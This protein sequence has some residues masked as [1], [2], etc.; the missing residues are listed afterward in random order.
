MRASRESDD[1]AA[2]AARAARVEKVR[3]Y[4]ETAVAGELDELRATKATRNKAVND[5]AFNIGQLITGAEREDV[6]LDRKSLEAR[7]FEAAQSCGYVEKDGAKAATDTIKSGLDAGMKRPRNLSE[8]ATKGGTRPRTMPPDSGAARQTD[9]DKAAAQAARDL[10][11]CGEI[12]A[13]STQLRRSLAETYLKHRGVLTDEL[14]D[15][16][17]R[18]LCFA[19]NVYIH[20][21]RHP[22]LI[23]RTSNPLTGKHNG[24]IQRTPIKPDGRGRA[25][26]ED[27]A[28]LAKKSLAKTSNDNG[29][30]VIG[31]IEPGSKVYVAEGVEDALS[32]VSVAGGAAIVTLG[33]SRLDKIKLPD[34]CR[35]FFLGQK[36]KLEDAAE[37]RKAAQAVADAGGEAFLVWPG[38]H[39]DFNELLRK[40]G[41]A[42]VA[43]ALAE[44]EAAKPD[45]SGLV[46]LESFTVNTVCDDLIEDV[47]KRGLVGQL[48]GQTGT[49]KSVLGPEIGKC[50]AA[51]RDFF[52]RRTEQGP[53][54][55]VNYE[56]SREF[57]NRIVGAAHNLTAE[58]HE[59][60]KRNF[61]WVEAAPFLGTGLEGD[62]G[63]AYIL[64]LSRKV[65]RAR[66]RLPV[67]IMID[68]YSKST[69]GNNHKEGADVT[70][71]VGRKLR[72]AAKTGAAVIDI[73]HPN[74][75]DG[76]GMAGGAGQHRND[77]EFA[78]SVTS[79]GHD[80]PIP[81]TATREVRVTKNQ[82]GPAGN[83]L[84]G[85]FTVALR[86]IAENDRGN[87]IV[88]PI[89]DPIASTLGQP[90][91][92]S[93][94]LKQSTRAFDVWNEF[95][96]CEG[97]RIGRGHPRIPDGT[98]IVRYDALEA[99]CIEKGIGH[100]KQ[101][102]PK[103]RE[104][105]QRKAVKAGF[106]GC[107][108]AGALAY[109]TLDD[110]LVC[111]RT[112]NVQEKGCGGGRV[113]PVPTDFEPDLDP[114]G[115]EWFQDGSSE[116]IEEYQG[117]SNGVQ[118]GPSPPRRA[119]KG[120]VPTGPAPL[121]GGPS[122]EP[123]PEPSS[124]P[125]PEGQK[126]VPFGRREI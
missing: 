83:L 54:L 91:A 124:P 1:E 65:E 115:S 78:W 110:E 116:E 74:K 53:V 59:L 77:N 58:E 18:N 79:P 105:V 107:V 109:Y 38:E 57:G 24:A 121:R 19:E 13:G 126:V 118:A 64:E 89:I 34:G 25:T 21:A 120:S 106:E 47:L 28:T 60:F 14:T 98:W 82:N 20:G 4:V 15:A 88:T 112:D 6:T 46:S 32:A 103:Q 101:P 30:V 12:V 86:Q 84:V 75:S 22:C 27:G 17:V 56:S 31:D 125:G 99:R 52:G 69:A 97:E 66:G 36:K 39:G 123:A 122:L 95:N 85:E 73:H 2:K 26:D 67:L 68:T 81:I 40:E 35:L 72:I 42:A 50:I 87:P 111:W 92:K 43:K 16:H 104:K 44:P 41:R 90:R 70:A 11:T 113:Q 102:D 51:G 55:Y 8:V 80:D 62:K 119:G 71:F 108:R 9:A 117:G 3:A 5:A 48:V 49:G 45:T 96:H 100:S 76:S 94:K 114:F 61:F 37:F 33:Q 93:V 10:K 63:E 23:A 29:C 7:L